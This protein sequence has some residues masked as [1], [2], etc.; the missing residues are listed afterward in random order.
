MEELEDRRWFE[1]CKEASVEEDPERLLKLVQE[2][3]RLLEEK[4]AKLK[5]ELWL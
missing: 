2:I 5:K 1:L 3:N 4:E